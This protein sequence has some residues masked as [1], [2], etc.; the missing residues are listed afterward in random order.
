MAGVTGM[1][2]LDSLLELLWA[3]LKLVIPINKLRD[4]SKSRPPLLS[5]EPPA[6]LPSGLSLADRASALQCL[7]QIPCQSPSAEQQHL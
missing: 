6:T 1:E 5:I 2:D 7:E 4:Q 3:L